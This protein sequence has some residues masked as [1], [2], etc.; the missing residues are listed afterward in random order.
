[1]V[2]SVGRYPKW[3]WTGGTRRSTAERRENEDGVTMKVGGGGWEDGSSTEGSFG[4]VPEL[5]KWAPKTE[6][7]FIQ[8]QRPKLSWVVTAS[9]RPLES[10]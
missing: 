9:H 10:F 3:R 5:H 2:I 8:I 4:G 7:K 1:M 6:C